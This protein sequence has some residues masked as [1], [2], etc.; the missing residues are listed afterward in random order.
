MDWQ[1]GDEAFVI[2]DE[3][4]GAITELCGAAWRAQPAIPAAGKEFR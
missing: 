1:R 3:P 4:K 2:Y